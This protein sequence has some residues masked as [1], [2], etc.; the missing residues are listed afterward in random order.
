ERKGKERKGKERKGKERKGRDQWK[1]Q[2]GSNTFAMCLYEGIKARSFLIGK[3][4]CS[5]GF[6]NL[7]IEKK[8]QYVSNVS[9][10]MTVR[11]FKNWL[12]KLN[13]KMTIT[14]RKILLSLENAQEHPIGQSYTN[15]ELF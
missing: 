5:K 13:E 3:S 7:D 4:K 15:I 12:D 11:I 10:R 1:N 6:K 8:I 9:S 2:Q 14:R